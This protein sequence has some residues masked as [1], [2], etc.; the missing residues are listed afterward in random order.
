[1]RQNLRMRL[2]LLL[3]LCVLL[4]RTQGQLIGG[5]DEEDE[6]EEEEE[7]ESVEDETLEEKLQRKNIKQDSTLSVVRRL[8][9]TWRKKYEWLKNILIQGK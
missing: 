3:G 7:E 5:L 2:V 8:M 6:E 4:S 9:I 1:M